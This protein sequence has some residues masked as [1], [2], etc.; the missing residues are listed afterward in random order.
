MTLDENDYLTYQLYYASKSPR[1]KR[2]RIRSWISIT[3]AF[4]CLSY[5][6]YKYNISFLEIYFLIATGLS[7]ILFPF[8]SRWRYK[9]HYLKYVRDTYKNKFGEDDNDIDFD[10]D[11]VIIKGKGSEVKVNKSEIEEVDEIRDF[12][13]IKTRI[14]L[15]LIISKTKSNDIEKINNEIRSM[16]ETQG[17]KHNIE[18]DW[19][20]R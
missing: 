14:G 1:V 13:F 15:I 5:L 20:W 8:Y 7:L 3:V 11:T 9:E 4:A 12:Y 19:K 10:D 17:L 6:F 18:L 2:A 16:V